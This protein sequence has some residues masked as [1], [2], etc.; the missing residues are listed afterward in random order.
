MKQFEI[1]IKCKLEENHEVY[2]TTPRHIVDPNKLDSLCSALDDSFQE[3]E[4]IE[5]KIH[6]FEAERRE[7]GIEEPI[8]IESITI[9]V[10]KEDESV[11][12]EIGIDDKSELV[13]LPK[14]YELLLAE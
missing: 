13:L 12:G 3:V 5:H 7:F 4:N 1:N 8:T 14:L 11:V 2:F 9:R 6:R 10:R